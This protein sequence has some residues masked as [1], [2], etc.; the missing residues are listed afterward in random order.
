MNILVVKDLSW[1]NYAL[2]S[3]R[4]NTKY[5]SPEHRINCFYGKNLKPMETI[6]NQNMLTVV[7][8]QIDKQ[9]IKEILVRIL[10]H[11]KYCII[12]HN[13]IEYNTISKLVIDICEEN[14]IPYFIFSEH[15]EKFYF[16]GVYIEDLKFKKCI[17][18]CIKNCI[19]T[20][21]STVKIVNLKDNRLIDLVLEYKLKF[22]YDLE[23]ARV[24]ISLV[25]E[26][27]EREKIC[28][29]IIKI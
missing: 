22:N 5:I 26:R 28:R 10:T 24:R 21:E 14:L 25:Y 13:F 6:C 27:T 29:Q 16:N 12:F 7:R 23:N 8:Q 4:I 3:K 2:I 20:I 15:C 17:K 1:D 9:K 18:N 19:K 11:T